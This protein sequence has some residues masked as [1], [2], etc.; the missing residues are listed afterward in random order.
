[1]R[2]VA[3]RLRAAVGACGGEIDKRERHALIDSVTFLQLVWEAELQWRAVG[4]ER[5][6]GPVLV[7]LRFRDVAREI[8]P[9]G[10]A[11][12]QTDLELVE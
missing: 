1:V 8:E 5:G 4:F 7:I 12:R 10:S 9:D 6:V 11:V 3:G 2:V